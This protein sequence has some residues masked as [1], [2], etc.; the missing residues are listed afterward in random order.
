[1]TKS[2]RFH[3]TLSDAWGRIVCPPLEAKRDIVYEQMSL[4]RFIMPIAEPDSLNNAGS[5]ERASS[6]FRRR[7]SWLLRTRPAWPGL[8]LRLSPAD[9]LAVG[10]GTP[11][12]GRGPKGQEIEAQALARL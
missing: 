8:I 5:V 11:N 2:V 3:Q 4:A 9:G 1:M 12:A 7:G 6:A 10:G